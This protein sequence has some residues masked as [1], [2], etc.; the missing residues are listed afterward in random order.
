MSP[1]LPLALVAGLAL[2]VVGGNSFVDSACALARRLGVSRALIGLTLVSLATTA[3]EFATSAMAA[4]MGSGG[5]AYGN[6]VG[7]CIANIA[8]ILSIVVVAL[9]IPIGRDRLREGMAML[10]LASL[11]VAMALDGSV[12]R[13]E[14][15]A[16]LL[17]LG[18]FLGFLLRRGRGAGEVAVGEGASTLRRL[19]LGFLAGAVGIVV[20]SRLLLYSGVGIARALGVPEA[21]IGFTLVAVGT[22]LPELATAVLSAVKRV[23]ELSLGNIIG[24]NVLDLTWVL[25]FAAALRPISIRPQEVWFSNAMMLA[26]MAFLLAFM[27]TGRRLSRGEGVALLTLYALYLAGLAVWH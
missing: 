20:G 6:V 7:S 3:P 8:L 19:V 10:A 1:L 26:V 22:S 15:L 14:G 12:G 17:A 25:G 27:S 13:L 18:L 4:L 16:L 2:I 11:V 24:A 5:V 9:S 21:V 23:P